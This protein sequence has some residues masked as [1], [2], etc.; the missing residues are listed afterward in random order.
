MNKYYFLVPSLPPLSLKERPEITFQKLKELLRVNLSKGDLAKTE[1]LKRLVDIN[2]IRALWQEEEIDPRGNLNEK[3]LDE[4]LLTHAHLPEYVFDYIG[5]F[6]KVSDRI[7]NISGLMAR[8]FQEEIPLQ[9]GFLKRYLTFE[10]EWRL[11]M[12][13]LRAK[14]TGRDVARELQFED[15]SDPLVAQ[16]L[17]QKDSGS[18]EPPAEYAELKEILD[19]CA[20]DPWEEHRLFA[21]WRF[22]KIE[23][24]AG[25][26]LFSVDQVLAYMAQLMLV[27]YANEL[28][29]ERGKMILDT[30]TTG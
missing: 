22:A 27:E 20:Y 6:E 8:F 13:G 26:A 24:M 5:Q 28:D 19:S 9:K 23:E 14:Q 25:S 18:Y 21:K 7:K 3:E 15:F 2:N 29:E 17:A 10:R 30:F 11:V 12:V 1:V 16:I 4:A